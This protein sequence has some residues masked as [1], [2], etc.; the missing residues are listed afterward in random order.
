MRNKMEKS[1]KSN[2]NWKRNEGKYNVIRKE[3][4][5]T[6]TYLYN[7]AFSKFEKNK[8][9]YN[10]YRG[11][12]IITASVARGGGVLGFQVNSVG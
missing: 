12:G 3:E 5:K 8:A 1:K 9:C 10:K 2:Q 6:L 7:T 11:W 4:R